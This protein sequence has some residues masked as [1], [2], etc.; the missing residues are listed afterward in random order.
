MGWYD[1]D[2][3]LGGHRSQ[4]FDTNG[5]AGPTIWWNGRVVG[6]WTQDGDGRVELRDCWTRSDAT[7]ARSADPTR[8]TN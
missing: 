5:N 3:Y 6:G 1:R 4:V 7:P 8:Q 2:W